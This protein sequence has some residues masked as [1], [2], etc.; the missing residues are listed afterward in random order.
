MV[1][2]SSAGL[3][4]EYIVEGL[5][6]INDRCQKLPLIKTH[7]N[8]WGGGLQE[9]GTL[10]FPYPIYSQSVHDWIKALY[11]L[12]LTDMNYYEHY[13]KIKDKPI[14]ELTRDEILTRMTYLVRAE[15]FCDGVIEEA[16]NDGTLEALS[17][18]LYE[19]TKP[20]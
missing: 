12:D 18:R 1:S 16:L 19:I 14:E 10:Q 5:M 20:E 3:K 13:K 17:T 2:V 7:R 4:S 8:P 6:D 11:N 9:D 15:R